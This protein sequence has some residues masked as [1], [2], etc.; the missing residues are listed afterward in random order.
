MLGVAY[1]WCS[2]PLE[3]AETRKQV[4]NKI[5]P[6]DKLPLRVQQVVICLRNRLH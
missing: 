3:R 1:A 2:I 6:K 4:N 5:T